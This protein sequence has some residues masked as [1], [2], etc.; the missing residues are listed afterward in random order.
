MTCGRSS[1]AEL[2]I[3]WNRRSERKSVGNGVGNPLA[4]LYLLFARI[5][6]CSARSQIGVRITSTLF[7]VFQ[8]LSLAPLARRR[9]GKPRLRNRTS[10][11]SGTYRSRRAPHRK[12]GHRLSQPAITQTACSARRISS[13]ADLRVWSDVSLIALSNRRRASSKYWAVIARFSS[14]AC[15]RARRSIAPRRSSRDGSLRRTGGLGGSFC[16]ARAAGVRSR[17]ARSRASCS[18]STR[19]RSTDT[20]PLPPSRRITGPSLQPADEGFRHNN[21]PRAQGSPPHAERQCE[22]QATRP[23]RTR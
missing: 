4:A 16:S 1:M 10:T 20:A 22:S 23:R 8:V 3:A 19:D 11:L 5:D 7:R 2:N 15:S 17:S 12:I 9:S 14:A 6:S 21:G 18:S 13:Y